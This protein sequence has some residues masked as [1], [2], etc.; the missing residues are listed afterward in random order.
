MVLP[1]GS[2]HA[3]GSMRI[4]LTHKASPVTGFHEIRVDGH[5]KG[6]FQSRF[7][8]SE[9]MTENGQAFFSFRR[10]KTGELILEGY[11]IPAGQRMD[12]FEIVPAAK[13]R[14]DDARQMARGL[15]IPSESDAELVVLLAAVSN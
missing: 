1:D 7:G 13:K 11:A 14:R 5:G 6:L 9:A 15:E 8:A 3:P 12:V 4:C 10:A 2:R